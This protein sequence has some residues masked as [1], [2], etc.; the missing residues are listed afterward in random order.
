MH[1]HV[2]P[3]TIADLLDRFYAKARA[4]ERLGPVFN[5]AV[6]DWPEHMATLNA[7]WGSI[8]LASR[9]YKGNPLAMHRALPLTPD[10][11]GDWLALWRQTTGEMFTPELAALFVEKAERIAESLKAG[12][13]FNP[14]ALRR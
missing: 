11:F 14:A 7:F 5:A 8:M 13:F 10:L 3:Q 4:H 6:D 2:T 12:L 1:D 9:Q